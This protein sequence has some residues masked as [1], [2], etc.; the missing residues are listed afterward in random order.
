LS[1]ATRLPSGDAREEGEPIT[2]RLNATDTDLDE[3]AAVALQIPPASTL[4]PGTR[5]VVLATAKREGGVFGRLLGPRS[6]AVPR[7]AVCTA[8]LVQGYVEIGASDEG[9]W[10]KAPSK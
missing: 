3:P 6:V 1:K 9:G 4:A 2:V 8:L 10:G 7:S 5:V